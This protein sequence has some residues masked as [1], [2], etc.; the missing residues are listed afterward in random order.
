MFYVPKPL[1]KF[2]WT[3]WGPLLH[4]ALSRPRVRESVYAEKTQS[5]AVGSR[6]RKHQVGSQEP[7]NRNSNRE[8]LSRTDPEERLESTKKGRARRSTARAPPAY[9]RNYQRPPFLSDPAGRHRKLSDSEAFDLLEEFAFFRERGSG[10]QPRTIAR[11][12]NGLFYFSDKSAD[13][14]RTFGSPANLRKTFERNWA[15]L[16]HNEI[17]ELTWSKM[18]KGKRTGLNWKRRIRRTELLEQL[19]TRF[20]GQRCL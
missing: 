12:T 3:K 1:G 17:S 15:R 8:K 10:Q 5:E 20:K 14:Q 18:R 16:E 4:H 19:R 13:F 11:V 9:L 2:R 6:A 7:G